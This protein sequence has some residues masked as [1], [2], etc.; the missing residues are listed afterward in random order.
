[1]DGVR[2]D[3]ATGGAP[4]DGGDGCEAN[5]SETYECEATEI[6]RVKR[7]ARRGAKRH[8]GE[9]GGDG[10]VRAC[11]VG[12]LHATPGRRADRDE[13]NGTGWSHEQ[14]QHARRLWQE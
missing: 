14:W 1:M 2:C 6:G 12:R 13:E 7:G 5:G 4:G 10:G 9:R 8:G 11:G 3:D